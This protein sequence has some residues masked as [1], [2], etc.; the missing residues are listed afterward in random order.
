M[1]LEIEKTEEPRGLRLSGELD[2][3]NVDQ[4]SAALESEIAQGGDVTLGLA[5]LAFMDSSGI[6]AV[7]KAARDLGDRG[8]LILLQPGNAVRRLRDLIPITQLHNV[9]VHDGSES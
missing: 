7:V 4:L 3:S 9:E 2:A 5:G 1:L 6:Q 8:T